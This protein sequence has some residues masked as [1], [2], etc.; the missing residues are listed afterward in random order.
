MKRLVAAL[1]LGLALSLVLVG[2]VAAEPKNPGCAD[3]VDATPWYH[4]SADPA[5]EH[6]VTA[7][8]FVAEASCKNVVYTMSVVTYDG[9]G[10][11]LGI[12][13]SDSARGD[14]TSTSVPGDA[15]L[16][17]VGGVTASFACVFFTSN[18]GR[19]V[20]DV[21]ADAGCPSSFD[22]SDTNMIY[23]AGPILVPSDDSPGGGFPYQ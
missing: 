21:A 11:S 15:G 17:T 19:H 18:T 1:A 6:T 13:G 4:G 2:G 23:P 22:T 20:Y 9:S 14:G 3:I 5:F 10:Q 16:L 8:V 7:K 12:V